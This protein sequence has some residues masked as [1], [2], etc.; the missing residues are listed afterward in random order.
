MPITKHLVALSLLLTST[1]ANSGFAATELSY[2]TWREQEKPLWDEINRQQLIAGVKV[3]SKVILYESY[4][5]HIL[6]ELQNQKADLF[7]WAPGASGL[8]ELIDQGFIGRYRGDLDKINSS[9]LLAAKGPDGDTYGVPFALQLQ[10]LMVNNKLLKKQ[11][12]RS[13]PESM[14]ELK[15]VFSTLKDADI[16]PLHLAGGA[17]W[18]VSQLLGEVLMAGL[19]DEDFAAGLVNGSSCFSDDA[20]IEIFRTLRD[21]QDAGY[22]NTNAAT[23]NYGA[24]NNSIALGSSAMGFDGG[25]KTGAASNFY[26]V[27][28]SY[29]F[30]FWAVPGDS[31]KI[32]ALG[33]GT[34]QVGLSS[35]HRDASERV[36]AFT[37]TKK[38]AE[39]FAKH[40]GELPAYG[41]EIY[42]EPGILKTM[43]AVVAEKTYPVS[44]FTAYQL[45]RGSPSYNELLIESIRAVLESQ[46][47]PQQAANAI[48]QGLNSWRYIGFD[49]CR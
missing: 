44:L 20:Y 45:N 46:Q 43:A 37:T 38:F 24:M 48:Q 33:D 40:V 28:P 6:L 42:I 8:K 10:S 3:N 34:Y 39:L 1:L 13:A 47:T 2:Y 29:E 49:R 32:Y 15:R 12:I 7:Q 35:K 19:V 18:Y 4:R 26:Q 16:T 25:W 22:L 31:S 5:P 36:L 41:G 11:G 14:D 30:D 23:E 9:A 17:N 21:W 27:D